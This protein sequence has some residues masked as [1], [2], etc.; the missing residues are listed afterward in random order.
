MP[1]RRA[2]YVSGAPIIFAGQGK[3]FVPG[4]VAPMLSA[5]YR[6]PHLRKRMG[7]PETS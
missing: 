3:G 2:K 6:H 5:G 7:A 1:Y 4:R